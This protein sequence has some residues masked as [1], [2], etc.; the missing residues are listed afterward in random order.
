MSRKQPLWLDELLKHVYHM[1][2]K[3]G[4]LE[5]SRCAERP[6]PMSGSSALRTFSCTGR[7]TCSL[8]PGACKAVKAGSHAL[9]CLSALLD[10][11]IQSKLRHVCGRHA[12]RPGDERTAA[13][14]PMTVT[15]LQVLQALA[16]PL[17][18]GPEPERE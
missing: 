3:E 1:A 15:G 14:P 18:T 17:E 10:T 2:D 5:L 9:T 12:H 7:A 11:C 6:A 16:R 4:Q 8:Q 13:V